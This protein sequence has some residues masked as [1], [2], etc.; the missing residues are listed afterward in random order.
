MSFL[1]ATLALSLWLTHE[2][3][4]ASG[5]HRRA[6]AAVLEDYPRI[7]AGEY[8]RVAREN[9]SVVLDDAFDDVRVPW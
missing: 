4:E 5:S 9:L 2:A 1:V 6:A 3:L 7:A 8:A